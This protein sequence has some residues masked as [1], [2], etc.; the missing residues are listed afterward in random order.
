MEERQYLLKKDKYDPKDFIY[1]G[2]APSPAGAAI[3]RKIDL[4]PKMSPIVNQ[5]SLG[6]CTANAIVSGLREYFQNIT[7]EVPTQ[8]SRLYLYWHER[9]IEG[10][11]NDDS[12]AYIRDG[13][14][15]LKEL[16][17]PPEA[18]F[19][20]DV[21]KFTNTPSTEAEVHATEY[22]IKEYHRVLNLDDLKHALA[23]GLP[24]VLGIAIY[25]SFE[26]QAVSLT[27][28]VPMPD[29]TKENLLGGHAVLA[30]GYDDDTQTVLARNSWGENWGKFGYFTLPYAF[31]TDST[32]TQDMW[33]GTP[34]KPM[35]APPKDFT[36][37]EAIDF[38]TSKGI[39]DSPGFWKDLANKYKDDPN[40]DFRFVGLAFIKLAK[41]INE[42]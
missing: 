39:F 32:L 14:K 11:V 33:T 5:G 18:Y 22:K 26:T 12:G 21:S 40:S 17:C 41:Y 29:K 31:I 4:S 25:S 15:V 1:K 24:V 3:P 6:S 9:F 19:P 10:T 2:V 13:M 8:L 38:I 23:S 16:G 28:N 35:P 27:G 20:Y 34:L 36:V 7:G 42:H 37:D 30:V